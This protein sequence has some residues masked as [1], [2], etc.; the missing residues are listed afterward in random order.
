[1]ASLGTFGY[2]HALPDTTKSSRLRSSLSL[3]TISILKIQDID[4]FFLE[5][6]KIKESRNLTGLEHILV[7]NLIFCALS[8]AKTNFVFSESNPRIL[9]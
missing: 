3:V 9:N 5:L 7:F 6:I 8:W 1:M 4:S 2:G